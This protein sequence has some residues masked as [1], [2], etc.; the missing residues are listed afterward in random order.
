MAATLLCDPSEVTEPFE[1]RRV[2][3]NVGRAGIT[4]LIP[5]Q[6]PCVR[7][8]KLE[9]WNLINHADFDGTLEDCFK[10]TTLH[11][12]FT[13]EE[14]PISKGTYG[15]QD[16]E[17]FLLESLVSVYDQGQWIADLNVLRHLPPV[18]H[19]DHRIADLDW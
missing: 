6:S 19:H 8:S 1:I 15:G 2:L 18:Y 4:M 5:P 16:T 11:L 13:G 17:V 9:S 3:G 7:E 10:N 14:I 12:S